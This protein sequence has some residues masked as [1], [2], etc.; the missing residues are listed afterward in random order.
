MAVHVLDEDLVRVGWRRTCADECA[1][2]EALNCL[3][4]G[5]V[6][7][8]ELDAER[9]CE[10][11][12]HLEVITRE[13]IDN[14]I[15]PTFPVLVPHGVRVRLVRG[16]LLEDGAHGL[17]VGGNGVIDACSSSRGGIGRHHVDVVG[18]KR[19]CHERADAR[20]D[21]FRQG[22]VSIEP[23]A[24]ELETP[25]QA[26]DHAGDVR[27]GRW[28][29]RC[30]ERVGARVESVHPDRPQGS[31]AACPLVVCVR[32]TRPERGE[33]PRLEEVECSAQLGGGD[34]GHDGE[35][36]I[37][38]RS[39]QGAIYAF[40]SIDGPIAGVGDVHEEG[41]VPLKKLACECAGQGALD[42]D[43]GAFPLVRAD[44][45]KAAAEHIPNANPVVACA[46]VDV[47]LHLD[48]RL[49][50]HQT[51]DVRADGGEVGRAESHVEIVCIEAGP[52][53]SCLRK[54]ELVFALLVRLLKCG[55]LLW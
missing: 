48:L 42:V 25:P 55:P 27:L 14:A 11:E 51:P 19:H 8:N 52:E 31:A 4:L 36:F 29:G 18:K 49:A 40:E 10:P 1:A 50:V 22:D 12:S 33:R 23:L 17:E 39:L 44:A 13:A 32:Y 20:T 43:H 35:V 9:V 16:L 54:A 26:A 53:R 2:Q 24:S 47:R 37:A 46:V 34:G 21:A 5:D 38:A 6:E 28:V 41:V 45:S 30:R 3:V 15:A 7:L